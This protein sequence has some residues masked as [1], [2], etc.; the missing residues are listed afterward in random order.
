MEIAFEY[1]LAALESTRGTAVNPPTR[2]LNMAGTITPGNEKYRPNES[3]GTLAEYY[4]SKTVRK[5]SDWQAEGPAD[6]YTLPV[7]LNGAVKGGVTSPS[8]PDGATNTRLWTFA[9]TMTS[10]DLKSMTLYGADPNVQAIQAA[11]SMVDELTIGG[12]SAGT[13]GVK[14]SAKGRGHFPAKTAPSSVPAQLTAPLLA[15]GDMQLWLDTSSAIGTSAITGRVLSGEFSV[16]NNLAY[17]W[18]ASG[19]ASN[20]NFYK[21]GRAKRHAELKLVFE[22]PDMAQYDLFGVDTVIK[23]RLRWN[24]PLIE[25]GFYHYIEVDVY[26]A[27]DAFSWGENE[28]TNRTIEMTIQSEYNTTAGHDFA[29]R[30]QNDRATL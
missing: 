18:V 26:G 19:P 22:V 4:R 25:S 15:P 29:V 9:P 20:L 17:K 7:L 8:T 23:A 24:G 2:Y 1:L 6:V 28:G 11:F 10:D 3:R 16:A 13:D 27:F 14:M 5:F 12:D 21:I 30:V